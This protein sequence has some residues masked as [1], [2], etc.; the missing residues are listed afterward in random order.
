MQRETLRRIVKGLLL[1]FSRPTF[2]GT[3]NLPKE[4][5]V[6]VAT[7]HMSRIDTMLLFINPARTDITA[8]VADKYQKYPLFKWVLDTGGIIWLDRENA[9]FGALRA[10]VE[11]LKKGLALGIAPEGTRSDTAQLLE[12]KP[13]TVLVALRAN[14]PIVPVGIACSEDFFSKAF[15]LRRPKMPLSFGKPF[16]F[17][18]LSRDNR[19]EQ[20]ARYTTEI[21]CRIAAQLPEKYHGFYSG[22]PRIKELLAQ[23]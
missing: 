16:T 2:L 10:A 15:T 5:G 23:G 21:M 1:T 9:D 7:N 17:E 14:V 6:I 3:E 20:M 8:L 18:P 4:G 22:H 19:D 13:G 12:G 11:A